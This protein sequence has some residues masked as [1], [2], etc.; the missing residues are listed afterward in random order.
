MIESCGLCIF[1]ARDSDRVTGRVEF[2]YE[3]NG[4]VQY[5]IDYHSRRPNADDH[6]RG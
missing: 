5:P 3:S 2:P 1:A 6:I 4:L